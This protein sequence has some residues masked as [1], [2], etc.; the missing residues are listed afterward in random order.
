MFEGLLPLVTYCTLMSVT[1]G[2]NN[3][4]VATSGVNFGFKRTLPHL[5]G[6]RAGIYVM[7][8]L[9]C[10]GLGAVFTQYPQ[11]HQAMKILG[12]LYLVYLA[13]K[14]A[15]AQ[16]ANTG[17]AQ[18]PLSFF[19]GAA[20]QLVNPKNWMVIVTVATMFMPS[21]VSPLYGALLV[22]T[23]HLVV[24]FPSNSVWALFGVGIRR[25]LSSE[26]RLRAFNAAMGLALLALA[27]SL[28]L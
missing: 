25:L 5:L 28:M 7:T 27:I 12:A 23:V 1:P 15:G 26:V 9:V 2:P 10:L 11:M 19:E 16:V 18:K 17:A 8:V 22:A 14:L 24:G 6:I 13:W 21:G 3:V 20:F 4:M